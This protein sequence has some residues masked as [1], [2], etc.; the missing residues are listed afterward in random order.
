M[1]TQLTNISPCN[2][3]RRC[4]A[5]DDDLQRPFRTACPA[6]AVTSTMRKA[7]TCS[8]KGRLSP[9]RATISRAWRSSL[10]VC[11]AKGTRTTSRRD[12][13][14]RVFHRLQLG[15]SLQRVGGQQSSPAAWPPAD[16][17]VGLPV[18]VDVVDVAAATVGEH[19][20]HLRS[21]VARPDVGQ[22]LRENRRIGTCRRSYPSDRRN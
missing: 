9:F 22:A 14:R 6:G 17:S 12:S 8:R 19:R 20:Q 21:L 16:C 3:T 11:L 7:L 18:G 15:V 1:L 2:A 13:Q 5:L 10:S 4:P